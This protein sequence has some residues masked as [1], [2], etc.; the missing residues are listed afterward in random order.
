[1]ENPDT[2]PTPQTVTRDLIC[3]ICG[4]ILAM[5]VD[6]KTG[7]IPGEYLLPRHE[8]AGRGPN[9]GANLCAG[10]RVTVTFVLDKCGR[11]EREMAGHPTGLCMRCFGEPDAKRLVKR[12]GGRR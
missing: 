4:A 12:D 5:P 7:S 11:C 9:P 8:P 3:P 2:V 6:P 1:M 10:Y